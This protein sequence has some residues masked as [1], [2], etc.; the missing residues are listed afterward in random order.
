MKHGR[1]VFLRN[2]A[3]LLFFALLLFSGCTNYA[4]VN[5][6]STDE[7]VIELKLAHFFPATH[8]AETQL[9]AGW[10]EAVDVATNGRVKIISYPGETLRKAADIYSGV[11][12]GALDIGLSC[13]SYNV[14]L[15]PILEAFE[16]PGVVYKNSKVASKVAWEGIKELQPEEVSDT[17]LLMVI[18]TGPGDIFSKK[19]IKTLDDMKGLQI[20]ATGLSAET[21]GY[22]GATPVGMPQSEAYEALQKG[23]VDG[24]LAPIEVLKAWKHADVTKYL[25]RTPFMYNTLFY[26]TMN[27]EK[28]NSLPEDI[29]NAIT[30]TT[31]AFIEETAIG[32]WDRQNEDAL[33]WAVNE[34]GM[35]VIELTDE[36]MQKWIELVSPVQEKYLSENGEPGRIALETVKRLAEKYNKEY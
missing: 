25:T 23:V 33:D 1:M 8:P 10:A 34:K 5:P 36:E 13:F 16:Q 30:H 22:L 12:E 21:L 19:P 9:V 28:W 3:Y 20:R 29:Q 18:A 32:L 17:K 26:V 2:S 11:K 7:Q 35:E 6:A 4:D 24:N 27:L 15:F 31:E 14:G